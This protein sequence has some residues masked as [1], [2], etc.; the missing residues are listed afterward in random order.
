MLFG[1][2]EGSS[3]EEDE[4]LPRMPSTGSWCSCRRLADYRIASGTERMRQKLVW[5]AA[6]VHRLVGVAVRINLFVDADETIWPDN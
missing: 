1:N 5:P 4:T 3:A 2:A 6:V